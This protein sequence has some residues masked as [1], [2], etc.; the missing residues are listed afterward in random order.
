MIR[1]FATTTLRPTLDLTGL[2]QMETAGKREAAWVPGCRETMPGYENYRGLSSYT[3]QIACGGN[4]L[5]TFAGVSHTARVFLDDVPLGVHQG[6]YTGFSLLARGVTMGEHTLRVEVDNA[7]GDGSALSVPNDYMTYGGITRPCVAETVGNAWLSGLQLVPEQ[8]PEGWRLRVRVQGN[9][10]GEAFRGTLR[11]EINGTAYPL[12]DMA[13]PAGGQAVIDACLSMADAR[14]YTPEQPV[15]TAVRC[16]LTVAGR[17]V[18][19][20]I[21]RT[22]F[23]VIALRGKDILFNGVP[24]KIKGF[25]RHEDHA[26]YG[27]ALPPAA[28]AQDLQLIRDLGGNAVRTC[29]YSNDPYFLDLCDEMGILVWE[30]AHARGLDQERM[31]H[32]LFLPQ[33]CQCIDEMI[34]RDISHPC[35]FIWGL[36]NE[37]ASDSDR[38]RPIY[39]ELMARIRRL[40]A[41]RPVTYATCRPGSEVS[42]EKKDPAPGFTDGDQCLP[43]CDVISFNSYP[44]WYHEADCGEYLARVRDWAQEHGG[45]DKPYIVSEIGAGAIYGFRSRA[46]E[47]WSEERQAELLQ[48]QLSAVLNDP[49][50]CGVFIW[51][52]ADCRVSEEWFAGRPRTRNNKGVVD[53]YR[54]PKL[55]YDTVKALFTRKEGDALRQPDAAT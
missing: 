51:Q 25:N 36:L 32:P 33:S 42:G 8:G 12:G 40:D 28:M 18:D 14:E 44:G 47:K 30:E 45:A 46:H 6:A 27:C 31:L 20:Q 53:E 23:R 19:D 17:D 2:W 38:C 54:R 13:V 24:I 35:I 10:A 3:R 52:F 1:A 15:L 48:A 37:C 4:V 50:T 39:E 29:H 26:L 34:A 11:A 16:V 22:G 43:L 21:E 9:S 41:S 49:D 5:F 55:A 7:F